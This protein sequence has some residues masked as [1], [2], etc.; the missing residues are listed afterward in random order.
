MLTELFTNYC[1]SANE[2]VGF[3]SFRNDNKDYTDESILNSGELEVEFTPNLTW[4][5]KP[6]FKETDMSISDQKKPVVKSIATPVIKSLASVS[7][8]ENNKRE[9]SLINIAVAQKPSKLTKD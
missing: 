6:K 7:L 9:N 4:K 8:S 2:I 5:C 1:L 3:L